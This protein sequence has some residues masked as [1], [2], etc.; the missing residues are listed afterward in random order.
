MS[1]FYNYLFKDCL[2]DDIIFDVKFYSWTG[3]TGGGENRLDVNEIWQIEDYENS[4]IYGCYK[5]IDRYL[6]DEYLGDYKITKT[7][8]GDDFTF[9]NYKDCDECKSY[10]IMEEY[11]NVIINNT[12]QVNTI[13]VHIP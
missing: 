11:E 10:I 3:S 9:V 1:T 12:N 8:I 5:I 2:N 7:L 4:E 13:F 6:G